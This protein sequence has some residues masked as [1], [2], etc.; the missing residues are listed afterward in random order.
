W[1]VAVLGA[2]ERSLGLYRAHGLH[3]L[4]HGD[5]AV[6][7]VAGFSLEGRRIRKVRQ[8]VHRLER[9]GY[10]AHALHPRDMTPELRRELEAVAREWR[11]AEPERGFVMALDALFRLEDDDALFVAGFAPDGRAAG[12][13]HFALCPR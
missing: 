5:E 1:R 4:Y 11:G 6:I 9:A 13:P 2:S 3:F 12:F 8:S 10:R 7:D